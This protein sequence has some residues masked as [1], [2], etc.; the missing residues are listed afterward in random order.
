MGKKAEDSYDVA[1]K[2]AVRERNTLTNNTDGSS[3][4]CR[5][6][7]TKLKEKVI[8]CNRIVTRWQYSFT[9]QLGVYVV[10]FPF[11]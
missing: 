3:S 8:N 7:Y 9:N 2:T 10:W 5:E 6:G 4:S 1:P 11:V